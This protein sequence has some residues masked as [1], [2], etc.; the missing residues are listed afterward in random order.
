M[1]ILKVFSKLNGSMIL[2][3]K[4]YQ[5]IRSMINSNKWSKVNTRN[6]Y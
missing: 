3:I 5:K 1:I 4:F 6:Y 2:N